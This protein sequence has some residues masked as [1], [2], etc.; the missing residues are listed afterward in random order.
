MKK[1]DYYQVM[2]CLKNVKA[3]MISRGMP[4]SRV[5]AID[6]AVSVIRQSFL[7]KDGM[8]DE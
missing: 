8:R 3:E 6:D 4:F 2:K 7:E 5:R 1:D